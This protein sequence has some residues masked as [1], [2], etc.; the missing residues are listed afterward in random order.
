MDRH[1]KSLNYALSILTG[2]QYLPYLDAIYLYGSCARGE[3]KY[4]SDVDLLLKL[5]ADVPHNIL[6]TMRSEATPDD[7]ELPEVELEFF[8]GSHFSNSH[9]FNKNLEKEAVLIWT[10]N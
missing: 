3:Q 10:K 2:N 8:S 9:Q 4:A 7:W 1:E 5:K 6:R